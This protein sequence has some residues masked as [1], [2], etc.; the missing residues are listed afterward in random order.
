LLKPKMD[1]TSVTKRKNYTLVDLRLSND[2]MRVTQA[3]QNLTGEQTLAD[4]L[5]GFLKPNSIPQQ[6]RD[7]QADY[8]AS[9]KI[10]GLPASDLSNRKVRK[11]DLAIVAALQIFSAPDA[12]AGDKKSMKMALSI[13]MTETTTSYFQQIG[14]D[15]Y[16]IALISLA[17]DRQIAQDL[18]S[19]GSDFMLS[20][21]QAVEKFIGDNQAAVTQDAMLVAGKRYLDAATIHFDTG[22]ND[23]KVSGISLRRERLD[24]KDYDTLLNSFRRELG[25]Y[26][27][28]ATDTDISAELGVGFVIDF[29]ENF[30]FFPNVQK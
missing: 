10:T 30:T 8:V 19:T 9:L 13:A 24:P 4:D 3:I 5:M 15:P 28:S 23:H 7:R 2:V 27:A 29:I 20:G 14:L 6:D 21:H 26:L 16:R 18:S 12:D 22:I 17:I 25:Y 1:E 11:T